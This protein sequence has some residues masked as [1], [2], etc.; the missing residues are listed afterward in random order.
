MFANIGKAGLE[1]TASAT[2]EIF[3]AGEDEDHR[4]LIVLHIQNLIKTESINVRRV[5]SKYTLI[6]DKPFC[7][8]VGDILLKYLD[9]D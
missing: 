8:M 4:K 9:E 7:R 6:G 2:N 5:V 1:P 3:S